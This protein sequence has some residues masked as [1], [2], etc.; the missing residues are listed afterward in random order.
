MVYRMVVELKGPDGRILDE[1]SDTFGVRTVEI[2]DRIFWS[3]A[4]ELRL[5]GVTRHKDHR[6][7]GSLKHPEPCP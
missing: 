6:G 3:M 4:S 5:T 1:Q 2:R 7:K